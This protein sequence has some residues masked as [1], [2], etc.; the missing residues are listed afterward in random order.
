[1]PGWASDPALYLAAVPGLFAV[2]AIMLAAREARTRVRARA[3]RPVARRRLDLG[4]SRQSGM[5][6]ALLPV[7]AFELGNVAT[8]LLILRATEL[9]VASGRSVTSA[10]SLAI[11]IYAGHNVAATVA[12]L[13]GGRWLDRAG[14]R[15][16]FATGVAV[17]V[18]AYT[19]FATPLHAPALLLAA[20]ALAGV[21]IG[22]AE[23]AESTCCSRTL[24]TGL[25]AG[26]SSVSRVPISNKRKPGSGSSTW[27]TLGTSRRSVVVTHRNRNS[28]GGDSSSRLLGVRSAGLWLG[29]AARWSDGSCHG[30]SS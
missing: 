30:A 15:F 5:I 7:A 28:G 25:L 8:T 26:Q 19:G 6:R 16:V 1:L 27:P 13:L 22:L 11:L 24:T 18:L 9:L 4:A 29:A 14:P 21:G 10:T 2:V 20:F 3:D 17:Y 23:T 12:A